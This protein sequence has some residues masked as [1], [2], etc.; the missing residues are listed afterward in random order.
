MQGQ[1]NSNFETMRR[2]ARWRGYRGQ[3]FV[4]SNDFAPAFQQVQHDT[5]AYY[6]LGYQSTNPRRD[7]NFRHLTVKLLN[8]PD[9]KLEYRPGYYAPADF[10]HAKSEDRELAL[11]EQMR[12]DVPATDVQ[13]FLQ[14]LYFRLDDGRFYIPV[15]SCDPR[16]ADQHSDG[17]GQGQGLHRHP[18]AGEE[19]HWR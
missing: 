19:R 5:E 4:D 12:S 7:G 9:A 3:L 1:L 18:G 6:I 15:S 17:K 2:W 14:A 13:I 11:T 10:Q 16:I 8:H